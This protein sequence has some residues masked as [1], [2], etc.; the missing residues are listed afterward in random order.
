VQPGRE[1]VKVYRRKTPAGNFAF[2]VANYADGKRRFD[3]FK[4]ESEAMAA[5]ELLARRIDSRNYV[6][7]NLT[8]GEATEYANAINQ[9][10]PYGVTLTAAV[11]TIVEGIKLTGSLPN[12]SAAFRFYQSN[13]RNVTPKPVADVIAELLALKKSR[14]ASDRPL[15]GLLRL[16]R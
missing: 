2:M 1:I 14:G 16:S 7:A 15:Y 11:S 12:A 3:S 6:A 9:L 10:V 13:H 4:T 5:A 8:K